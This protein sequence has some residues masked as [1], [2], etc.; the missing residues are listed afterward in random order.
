MN[1][2]DE[3]VIRGA[4]ELALENSKRIDALESRLARVERELATQDRVQ[5]ELR[6]D[7][8]LNRHGHSL[9]IRD[10]CEV[11]FINLPANFAPE[12]AEKVERFLR[13]MIAPSLPTNG[14]G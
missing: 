7:R 4:S 2:S 13:T 14:A 9:R 11:R 12:E 1:Q 5:T 8:A 10:D 6:R 3:L